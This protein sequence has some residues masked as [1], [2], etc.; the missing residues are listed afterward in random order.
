M[1]NILT[2]I[3][4]GLISKVIDHKK[5]IGWGAAVVFALASAWLGTNVREAVCSAPV[6]KIEYPQGQK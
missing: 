3:F 6:I 5:I 2:G 4:G 1:G